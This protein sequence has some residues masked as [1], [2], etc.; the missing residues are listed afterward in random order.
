MSVNKVMMVGHLGNDPELRYTQSGQPMASFRIAT[1]RRYKDRD[2][3]YVEDTQWHRIKIFGKLAEICEK[4]LE[5]GRQVFVEGRLEHYQYEKD[6]Q[7][8]Y[9]TEVVAETV[10]FLGQRGNGT[11]ASADPTEPQGPQGPY[12]DADI[13]F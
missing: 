11:R 4:Y 8:R 2:G 6:G 12:E 1:N 7:T 9:W 5:K 10:Q 13:P 3:E